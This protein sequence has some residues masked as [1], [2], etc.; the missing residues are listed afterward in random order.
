[1]YSKGEAFYLA[2]VGSDDELGISTGELA[3]YF[4]YIK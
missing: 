2:S 1:M 4:K 3:L